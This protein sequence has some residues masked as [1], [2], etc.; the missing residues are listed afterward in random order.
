MP[1]SLSAVV[2]NLLILALLVGVVVL[3]LRVGQ[4]IFRTDTKRA[5]AGEVAAKLVTLPAGSDGVLR[6]RFVRAVTGQHVVMPSGERLAFGSLVV[7]LAPEDVVRLDPDED[8]ERLGADAARLYVAHAERQD[9]TVPADVRVQV[10]V[11][12][13]LRAG[14]IP[15]ARGGS[16]APA[17]GAVAGADAAPA[18]AGWSVLRP[19]ADDERR[20]EPVRAPVA[21]AATTRFPALVHDLPDT[22]T[23]PVLASGLRLERGDDAAELTPGE[24]PVLGRVKASPLAL[25]QPEVSYRH[26][27]LRHARGEWQV[28]DLGSTNGTTVDGERLTPDV[29]TTVRP[30]AELALAGVVVTVTAPAP[31]TVPVRRVPTV[32]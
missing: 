22:G 30:G 15:P 27:T 13:S 26:A 12:P 5:A 21:E 19:A 24:E 3:L 18:A 20:P 29:W 11:D 7:R 2:S 14:W 32:R 16:A 1:G 10:E 6:R 23:M 17:R 31:G 28:K 9:W 25:P 8:L 4:A